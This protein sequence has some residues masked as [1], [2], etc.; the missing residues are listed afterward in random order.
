MQVNHP[1]NRPLAICRRYAAS[2]AAVIFVAALCFAQIGPEQ[3]FHALDDVD[4]SCIICRFSDTQDVLV[5][6]DIE[7]ESTRQSYEQQ[8]EHGALAKVGASFGYEARA[9]P[10]SS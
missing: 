4:P 10:F 5:A 2:Q 7:P 9:P 1:N 6:P 3:H 8:T